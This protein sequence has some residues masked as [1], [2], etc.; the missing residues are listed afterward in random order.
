MILAT[1]I[2]HALETTSMSVMKID[3]DFKD[4]LVNVAATFVANAGLSYGEKLMKAVS[5]MGGFRVPEHQVSEIFKSH[6]GKQF[7]V[8]RA[9]FLDPV[10]QE[11]IRAYRLSKDCG[12]VL[13]KD[14][15][16]KI[17]DS[18]DKMNEIF[19]PTVATGEKTGDVIEFWLGLLDIAAM[20]KGVINIFD[21]EVDSAKFLNHSR[22]QTEWMANGLQMWNDCQVAAG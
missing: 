19:G 5:H 14:F 10:S 7:L 11:K 1:R 8:M 6:R 15:L 9:E 20:T 3:V 13:Y 17:L 22:H 4:W 21:D 12:N 16:V 2:Q 18:D